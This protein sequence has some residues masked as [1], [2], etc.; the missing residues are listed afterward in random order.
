MAKADLLLGSNLG[1]R[2][3]L[4]NRAV[5]MISADAGEVCAQSAIFETEP[6]GN[7]KGQ[8]FLN[9]AIQINTM[10]EPL[11][12]LRKLKDIE[13]MLGRINIESSGYEA[14]TMDIDIL[15]YDDLVLESSGLIIPH[16]LLHLRRFVLVPLCEMDPHRIHPVLGQSIGQLLNDCSDGLLVK[17]YPM[18]G[19]R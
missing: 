19:S 7:T 11:L 2:A 10:L 17:L 13:R 18:S 14:R 8:W 5:E 9:C 16:P 1:D 6:W 12:L 15:L 3:G 4:L